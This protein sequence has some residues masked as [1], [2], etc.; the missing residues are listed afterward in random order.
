MGALKTAGRGCVEPLGTPSC[1][2]MV[3]V[4]RVAIFA[5]V[6][7]LSSLFAVRYEYEDVWELVC[8][9]PN[10]D[11]AAFRRYPIIKYQEYLARIAR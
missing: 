4:G 1:V 9:S 3:T 6:L 2:A 8:A 10:S 7:M 5:V 11:L